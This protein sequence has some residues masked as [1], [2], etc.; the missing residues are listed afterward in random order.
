M[1]FTN[2]LGKF[3]SCNL[4]FILL[5]L[6]MVPQVSLADDQFNKQLDE[7]SA[8]EIA[9]SNPEIVEW[10]ETY[11]IIEQQIWFYSQLGYWRI[12]LTTSDGSQTILVRVVVS[13]ESKDVI[14]ISY[15][16]TSTEEAD[17]QIIENKAIEFFT[18]HPISSYFINGDFE[19]YASL[20]RANI[21]RVAGGNYTGS[22]RRLE[23]VAQISYNSTPSNEYIFSFVKIEANFKFGNITLSINDVKDLVE[24]DAI[25][26]K[27]LSEYSLR[28]SNSRKDVKAVLYFDSLYHNHSSGYVY[29]VY[30]RDGQELTFEY[31][32]GTYNFNIDE[33]RDWREAVSRIQLGGG[34]NLKAEIDPNTLSFYNYRG[35]YFVKDNITSMLDKVFKAEQYS[36][37]VSDIS[38][39]YGR[40]SILYNGLIDFEISSR[41]SADIGNFRF[42]STNFEL[43]N[44]SLDKSIPPSSNPD[45]LL[46]IAYQQQ[47]VI[48]FKSQNEHTSHSILYDTQGT[49]RVEFYNPFIEFNSVQVY[50]ND[51]SREISSISS[52]HLT[53]SPN[54]YIDD[55]VTI[56]LSS[57]YKSHMLE[58]P[59]SRLN[60][61]L[62]T[63]GYWNAHIFST[64]FPENSYKIRID[65][66]TGEIISESRYNFGTG[67]I[68][69]LNTF[70]EGVQ[71]V[72]EFIEFHS[73]YPESYESFYY[74]DG[75][76]YYT[77]HVRSQILIDQLIIKDSSGKMDPI[78]ITKT[79]GSEFVKTSEYFGSSI[80]DF[81]TFL[82]PR[83][84]VYSG[85][86]STGNIHLIDKL[87]TFS[88]VGLLGG[89]LNF[90]DTTRTFNVEKDNDDDKGSPLLLIF[91]LVG[92]G[93]ITIVL[94]IRYRRSKL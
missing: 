57:D 41:I 71:T 65:D 77:E 48:D 78:T 13:D 80:D 23:L 84:R 29:E 63:E 17:S 92:G 15:Q 5:I 12:D 27:F 25:F 1:K 18:A 38:P 56:V 31:D 34:I 32:E 76:T 39:F 64:L 59:D 54:L 9:I 7:D 28:A 70:R 66:S 79:A 4:L 52:N 60:L 89:E 87:V 43:I 49:W 37:W 67:N 61:Y 10:L 74:N 21:V 42:N 16:D 62:L 73:K 51:S 40:I 24:T 53:T 3:S 81:D 26:S 47:E 14:S 2:K 72:P 94:I 30:Y 83:N 55:L 33:R 93:Y 88:M 91:G 6:S 44:Q 46:L 68:T 20:S 22:Y 86:E 69:S 85:G 75:W 90:G 82:H 35:S 8:F 58:F 36:E 50:I 19:I 11:E 45:A